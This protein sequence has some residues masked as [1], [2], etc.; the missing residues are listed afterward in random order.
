MKHTDLSVVLITYNHERFIAEAIESILSQTY[1]D[2]EFIIVND[3]ST[4]RTKEIIDGFTDE[5]I[6]TIHQENQGPSVAGNN[7]ILRA[8]GKYIAYVSGD[9]VCYPNRL[10][11]Q[12]EYCKRL[13]GHIIFSMCDFIGDDSKIFEPPDQIKNVF[14]FNNKTRTEIL[15]YLFNRGNY[16]VAP[17]LFGERKAFVDAGLFNPLYLQLQDYDLWIKLL[18]KKYEFYIVQEKLIKYRVRNDNLNI[19]SDTPIA[20]K[21]LYFEYSNILKN[22]IGLNSVEDFLKVFPDAERYGGIK[23]EFIPYFIARLAIDNEYKNPIHQNFGINLLFELL[24]NE[25]YAMKVDKEYGFKYTDFFKLSGGSD[26]FDID[27]VR[28]KR[29]L[30]ADKVKLEAEL[31]SK[32]Q[33]LNRIYASRNWRSLIKIIQIKDRM[34]PHQS[35]RIILDLLSRSIKSLYAVFRL[36]KIIMKEG[37]DGFIHELRIINYMKGGSTDPK[38][39]SWILKNEPDKSELRAMRL[40]VNSISYQPKVSIINPVFSTNR[41]DLIECLKSVLV[42][43][44]QNWELCLVDGCSDKPYVKEVIKQ[45]AKKDHRIKYVSLPENKGIAGNSNEALKLATGEYVAFLDHDDMLSPFAL[46]EEVTLLT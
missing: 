25:E 26:L 14:K 13:K 23:K 17:S 41:Y 18:L 7:G 16:I 3:G 37:N 8:K 46:Y 19:S 15:N 1:K 34:F 11:R 20:R 24:N 32:Q 2:F 38:Y 45:F 39:N 43:V 21:R 10:E 29:R 35:K 9:D 4:D 12:I 33:E 6:T 31:N 28:L 22:Y 5:R 27:A 44:Y 40:E 30:E 36:C 42:Q